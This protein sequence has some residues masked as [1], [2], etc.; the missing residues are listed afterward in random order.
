MAIKYDK[1]LEELKK[2][3]MKE[4]ELTRQA[5]FSGTL[6]EGRKHERYYKDR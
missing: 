2:R 1:L 3:N 4:I 5:G 6:R